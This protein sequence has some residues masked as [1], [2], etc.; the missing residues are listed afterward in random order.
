[1]SMKYL[2]MDWQPIETI[3]RTGEI[4]EAQTKMHG[5]R[6]LM[7]AQRSEKHIHV[8]RDVERK[9]GL[10]IPIEPTAWRRKFMPGCSS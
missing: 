1:M 10:M 7:C 4:V 8:W 2:E 9:G 3:P 6:L 5:N